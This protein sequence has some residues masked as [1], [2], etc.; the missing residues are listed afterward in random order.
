MLYTTA[1]DIAVNEIDRRGIK[2]PPIWKKAYIDEPV[3]IIKQYTNYIQAVPSSV[4][5]DVIDEDFSRFNHLI[6]DYPLDL[7]NEY[8]YQHVRAIGADVDQL[9]KWNTMLAEVLKDL[10]PEKQV[11]VLVLFVATQDDRYLQALEKS[12]LKGNK[13]DVIVVIGTTEFQKMEWVGIITW[14]PV[15][16]FKVQL[17]E[18]IQSV[19]KID[20]NLII[21]IIKQQILNSFERLHMQ[22]YSHLKDQIKPSDDILWVI[23]G[24]LLIGPIIYT[25]FAHKFNTTSILM[26]PLNLGFLLAVGFAID[27]FG[28]FIAIA[29]MAIAII[30]LIVFFVKKRN[31]SK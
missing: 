15:V 11:N 17:Q 27:Y 18:K 30:A 24:I 12:W 26:I 20:P 5:D 8:H 7:K 14:S 22:D 21:P 19:G 4:F 29:F 28:F 10:G 31:T 25:F 1:G 6:P 13:N 2:M 9:P 3:S 23:L 16:E